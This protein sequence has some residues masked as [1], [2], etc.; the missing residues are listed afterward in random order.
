MSDGAYFL[1]WL[2]GLLI[3][4]ETPTLWAVVKF[5][6]WTVT[7]DSWWKRADWLVAVLAFSCLGATVVPVVLVAVLLGTPVD[8]FNHV[9]KW[10]TNAKADVCLSRCV[11]GAKP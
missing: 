10:S 3:L 6:T 2:F 11:R 4:V 7:T 9:D 8:A 1:C 5:V